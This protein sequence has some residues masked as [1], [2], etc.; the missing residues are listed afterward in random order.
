MSKALLAKIIQ[1][2]NSEVINSMNFSH[3]VIHQNAVTGRVVG[4]M[5]KTEHGMVDLD[6][7]KITNITVALKLDSID[8]R[9]K[10]PGPF[11][12]EREP[13][14]AKDNPIAEPELDPGRETVG[15]F[16]GK[17]LIEKTV[18]PHEASEASEA[19]ESS[20]EIKEET[21]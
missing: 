7:G 11:A 14:S 21:F 2:N 1:M 4:S 10:R 18:E 17:G 15:P 20:P 13:K 19:S 16:S 6:V 3:L 12:A 8:P 5:L 9:T